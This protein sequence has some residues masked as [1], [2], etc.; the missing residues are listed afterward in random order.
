MS[1]YAVGECRSCKARII[2]TTSVKTGKRNPVDAVP[3][4]GGN[5]LLVSG[6][7]GPESRVLTRDEKERNAANRR[8]MYVSHFG[9]CPNA[10]SHRK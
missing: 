7:N 10:A 1:E 5:V 3:V 2:W 9:T 8:P 4:V 6:N